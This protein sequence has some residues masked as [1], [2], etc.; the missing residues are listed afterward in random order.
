MRRRG[1]IAVAREIV[2]GKER[3]ISV[4]T[5]DFLDCRVAFHLHNNNSAGSAASTALLTP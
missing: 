1:Q 3:L 2:V 5:V 4:E